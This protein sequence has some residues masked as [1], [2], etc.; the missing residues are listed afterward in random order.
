[1]EFFRDLTP[2]ERERCVVATYYIETNS[3][4]GDL[5]DA[6]WALAIGQSVGNPKVRSAWETDE[7]FERSSCVI[8]HDEPTYNAISSNPK[9]FLEGR[10]SGTVRIGFPKIN[11]DWEG[12]G[13]SHLLCQVMGGQMDID[14]FSVCRLLKLEFP[15]DVEAKF[16]GPKYGLSGIREFTQQKGKP[17]L[18]GIIKP[19]TGISPEILGEMVKELLDGGVDFIKEDEILSNPSFCRLTDRVELISN[20]IAK[21][22]RNVVYCFCINGDH[23]TILDRAKFVAENGGNGIH[24]NFWSGFGVYNS[25]RN[26]DLPLYLHFQKS[27]DKVITDHRHSFGID[28]NVICD[29]VGLAGV[30]TIHAGMWGGYLSDDEDELK[31]TMRVLHNRNVVPA[32]SC[33]M[34][35]GIVNT[36]A[37]KFG[38]DFIANCGGSIHGHPGG[39]VSGARA[40]RQ[41]IDRTGGKEFLQAVEK[42]G[43]VQK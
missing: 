37:S 21:H 35:P 43:Y 12:D 23:H 7:L 18:G 36:I 24:V 13:I 8:Y 5:R 26:L 10:S 38:N 6:A 27:G 34:H 15:K 33:G 22:G 2:E 31:E 11:T 14:V 28:W 25:I 41:A 4:F 1:M 3:K 40:M 42:W 9:Q 29:L 16:L 17:L 19:K 32:L 39:T 30:D 20:I